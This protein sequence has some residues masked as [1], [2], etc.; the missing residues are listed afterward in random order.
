MYIFII[1]ALG[2]LDYISQIS[3]N[4]SNVLH[5]II[6]D[7]AVFRLF[8]S[9][10]VLLIFSMKDISIIGVGHLETC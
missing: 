7:N 3:G 5:Y 10:V 4:N 8:L 1:K 2:L 6:F 9:V